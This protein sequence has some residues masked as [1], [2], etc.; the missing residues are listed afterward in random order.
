[1]FKKN[2]VKHVKPCKEIETL[3]MTGFQECY[4]GKF[5]VHYGK[6]RV[7][8][9]IFRVA[10]MAN[11]GFIMAFLGLLYG[12]FRVDNYSNMANH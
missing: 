7:Y 10:I 5:R 9:G 3:D 6:F 2:F 4:Y 11:S 1:M 12:K 8:Y